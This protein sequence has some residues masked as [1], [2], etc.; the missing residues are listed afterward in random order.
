MEMGAF[1]ALMSLICSIFYI[2]II[3]PLQSAIID[4][5]KVLEELRNDLKQEREKRSS[6]ETR[7]A[8]SEDS[9]KSLHKRVDTLETSHNSMMMYS[10][11]G[12]V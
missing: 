5:Q 8:V 3:K 11:H 7:I 2:L 6:L 1:V 4:L 12:K 10:K 9:L